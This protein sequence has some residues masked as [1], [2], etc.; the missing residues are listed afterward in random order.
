[1]REIKFVRFHC[2]I[3][4]PDA[5][6]AIGLPEALTNRCLLSLLRLAVNRIMAGFAAVHR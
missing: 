5:L 2:P 3:I 6:A 1:M 4:E